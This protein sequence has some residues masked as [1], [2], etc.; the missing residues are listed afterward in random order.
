MNKRI[1]TRFG[2]TFGAA[3]GFFLNALTTP[4]CCDPLPPT[5]GQTAL[6][7]VIVAVITA[8]PAAAFACLVS[9]LPPKPVV[10]LALL[11]AIITGLLLGPVASDSQT[12]FL[13]CSCAPS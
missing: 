6:Y 9:R 12:C 4:M 8:L 7:G 1:C 10:A 13:R 3:V 2:A 5:L 11:I